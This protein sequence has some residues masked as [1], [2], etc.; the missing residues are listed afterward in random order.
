MRNARKKTNGLA[1][2]LEAASFGFEVLVATRSHQRV[3]VGQGLEGIRRV[4]AER[5]AR[6]MRTCLNVAKRAQF[7]KM[8]RIGN[9]LKIALA[10]KGRVRLLE[11]RIAAAPRLIGTER[12]YVAFDFPISQRV[13]RDAFRRLLKRT[14]FRMV[15][16]SL[17]AT[18]RDAAK[19]MLELLAQGGNRDWV[20]I[21]RGTEK[22][23]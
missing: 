19:P 21:L 12:T 17:W 11:T 5:R 23:T 13:A 4:I 7:I 22:T 20:R 15:Q 8:T 16:M 6:E 1:E 18:K 9:R 14:G 2:A 3:L 10:Q